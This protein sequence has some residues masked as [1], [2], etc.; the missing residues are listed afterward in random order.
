MQEYLHRRR[1]MGSLQAL[2]VAHSGLTALLD[3]EVKLQV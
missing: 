3:L 2:N 1:T